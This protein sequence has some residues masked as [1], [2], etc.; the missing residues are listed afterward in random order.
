MSKKNIGR[1]GNNVATIIKKNKAEF[2][3]AD[4]D[5]GQNVDWMKKCAKI[6]KT[7]LGK[8]RS[9]FCLISAGTD[10]LVVLVSVPAEFVERVN[11][12][13]WIEAA[14]GKVGG[15]MSEIENYEAADGNS[16]SLRYIC[17]VEVATPFKVKDT[18]RSL[19]INYLR[20]SGALPTED[21]SESEEYFF[22]DI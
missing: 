20:K 13:K 16:A 5:L 4:V 17:T 10:K 2:Y 19:S 6:C 9:A 12:Q 7:T 1:D 21:D 3:T 11:G 15:T 18:I 14:A 8:F 22:D